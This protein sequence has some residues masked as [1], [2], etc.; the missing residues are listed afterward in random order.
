M[1]AV[2]Q[3]RQQGWWL[4]PLLTCPPATE[5]SRMTEARS[6]VPHVCRGCGELKPITPGRLRYG[7]VLCSECVKAR[8]T[9][10][11]VTCPVCNKSRQARTDNSSLICLP[12][13]RRLQASKLTEALAERVLAAAEAHPDECLKWPGSIGWHGYGVACVE[14]R[15]VRAHRFI[16]ERKFGAIPDGL[17]VLHRCD[18]P[19]CVNPRHLWLGTHRD[20]T[21]DMMAKGR[22]RFFFSGGA[23]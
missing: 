11:S 16:W 10:Q 20:N 6:S 5:A 13:T 9:M 4:P 1:Q 23:D 2:L 17:L 21:H 8:R 22:D 3:D 18:Y 15:K 14:T 7:I 19:A 12:C